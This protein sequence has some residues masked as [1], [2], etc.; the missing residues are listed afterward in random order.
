[1]QSLRA[2]LVV[3]IT[4]AF[5]A[6]SIGAEVSTLVLGTATPGG[7]FTVYGDAL[8]ETMRRADPTLDIRT[9]PTAGSKKTSP[10]SKRDRSIWRWSK[11]RPRTK[12]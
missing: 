7:G 2:A 12:R 9:R 3:A 5:T 10:C 11:A 8:A 1:M 4:L 6:A